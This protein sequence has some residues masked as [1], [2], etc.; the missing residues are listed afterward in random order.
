[1]TT[2]SYFRQRSDCFMSTQVLTTKEVSNRLKVSKNKVYEL[3]SRPDFPSFK[4]G[5][6]YHVL[7]DDLYAWLRQQHNTH[8]NN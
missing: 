6:T 3:F 2:Y 7:E 4:L 8:I 5:S 1:M